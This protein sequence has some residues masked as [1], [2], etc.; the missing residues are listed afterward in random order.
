MSL[1]NFHLYTQLVKSKDETLA[2]LAAK[3]LKEVTYH[4]R[5]SSN[6]MI[7]LGDGT[8]ESHERIQNAV[9]E[10]WRYTD[11]LFDTNESFTLLV[12]EGIAPDFTTVKQSWLKD[13]EALIAKATLT[14]PAEQFMQKGSLKAV[15]TEHLGYILAE[16][17]YM[18][19]AYPDAKW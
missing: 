13:V 6:W 10:L 5:H 14:I 8:E 12:K 11:D 9:N 1:Y 4:V 2:A 19:R 3:S 7:R 17:Q 16:M 18:Q 15:H